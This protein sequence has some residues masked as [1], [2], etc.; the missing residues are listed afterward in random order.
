MLTWRLR[1]GETWYATVEA[2]DAAAALEV[3][4]GNVAAS[5]YNDMAR[6]IW[7]RIR[8][9]CEET[10]E[11]DAD[12]VRLDPP[13][14]ECSDSDGHDWQCKGANGP[15]GF[16]IHEICASCECR[17]VTDTW[18]TDPVTGRQGLDSVSYPGGAWE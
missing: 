5:N 11:E 16:R 8:V 2:P 14:P 13:V 12:T 17:R 6:T 9:Q 10:G 18:A 3:A 7:I 4:R 1:E 15:G